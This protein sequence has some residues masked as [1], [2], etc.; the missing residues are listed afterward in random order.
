MWNKWGAP[1]QTRD[2][3]YIRT[4]KATNPTTQTN[5][6]MPERT[7]KHRALGSGLPKQ[8]G[9]GPRLLGANLPT[10]STFTPPRH[11]L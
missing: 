1:A 2:L 3:E 6:V 11:F 5:P 4:N 9:W 8:T 7:G 10:C